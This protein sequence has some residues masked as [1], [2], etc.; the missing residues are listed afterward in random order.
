[1]V[2]ASVRAL[3]VTVLPVPTLAWANAPVAPVLTSVTV[4]PESTPTRAALPVLRVAVVVPLYTM[5]DAV[6][7]VTVIGKAVI[8]AVVVGAVTE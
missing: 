3:T 2:P 6:T 4:S 7:P 8:L 5:L 1:M